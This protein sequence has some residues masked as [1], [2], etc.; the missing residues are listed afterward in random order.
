MTTLK[1]KPDNIQ[2]F[3][4]VLSTVAN[5][6]SCSAQHSV[7]VTCLWVRSYSSRATDLF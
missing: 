7:L 1:K 2:V 6:V 5:L 4:H 3:P